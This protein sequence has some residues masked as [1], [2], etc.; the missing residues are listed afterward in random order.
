MALSSLQNS[1]AGEV[2]RHTMVIIPALDEEDSIGRVVSKLRR[3]P[4][5]GIRVIDNGSTDNTAEVARAAGAEVLLEPRRGYG[6][7]CWAGMRGMPPSVRWVLFCDADGCDDLSGLLPFFQAG[8]DGC[9]LV[10]GD[11]TSLPESAAA[12]TPVQRFGNRFAG[13]LIRL[14]WGM[15]FHD[16]GP[17][18]LVRRSMLEA[19]ELRDRGFG[20]TVEMQAKAAAGGL[21]CH[22]VP[23]AYFPRRSGRSKIAGTISGSLKAGTVILLTLARLS[24]GRS[25]WKQP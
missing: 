2:C 1:P 8:A 9:D 12:L 10:L 15:R 3:W 11:R 13:T 5:A 22:E 6:A 19:M 14:R 24:L 18:R 25:G 4:L 21:R 16:L 17:L 23:A 20:W 7:A